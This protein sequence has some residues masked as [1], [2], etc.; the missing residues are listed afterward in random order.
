MNDRFAALEELS[1]PDD[2]AV[3]R[4]IAR[5]RAAL[6]EPGMRRE[7][8][9]WDV[10]LAAPR[11]TLTAGNEVLF[12]GP[13]QL[14]GTLVP[15]DGFLWGFANPSVSETGWRRARDAWGARPELVPLL[16]ERAYPV[17]DPARVER[18]ATWLALAAGFDGCFV[19]E[20]G[21]AIS[22]VAVDLTGPE[23]LG[24]G[25]EPWCAG[26]GRL[27]RS[28]AKLIAGP[29]KIHVCDVCGQ[30]LADLLASDEALGRS[31]AAAPLPET[32]SPTLRYCLLCGEVRGGLILL[33]SAG[34]CRDCARLCVE[35][36]AAPPPG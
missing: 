14:V 36:C 19:G 34:V 29:E 4:A 5:V 13:C 35:V 1:R 2:L 24:Q 22:F 17:D 16:A 11:F 25:H 18:V 12:G 26:C 15:G 8:E 7:D 31:D 33:G 27:R 32:A 21:E 28:V 23:A 30:L 10:D 3:A 9:R 6:G 20:V